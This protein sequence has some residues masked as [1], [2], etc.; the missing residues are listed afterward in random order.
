MWILF[1]IIGVLALAFVVLQMAIARDGPAVLS[2]VD[3]VFGGSQGAVLVERSQYGEVPAQ[4]LRVWR[5]EGPQEPLPIM[6]F[7][8]GGSW[9][10][11]DPDS[12][13]FVGRNL[14][15]QG[16][17]T[18]LAGYRLYPDARYP[19]MLKDTAA[20]IAWAREN[21]QRLGGDPERIWLMG[22]SAGA[23]NVVG[24]ALDQRWI[25]ERKVPPEA[26]AGVI[27][28]SGPYDF[29][30]FDSES[31]R[32]SFG[33]WPDPEATQPI[34]YTR[35]DAPKILLITG[36]Q[37]TTVKPR[38]S[39]ALAQAIEDKGGQVELEVYPEMDHSDPLVSL[40]HPWQS[41]RPVMRR[42]QKFVTREKFEK[43]IA[44][45]RESAA[46]PSL[47]VQGETR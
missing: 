44:Q 33:E 18:I 16:F 30:P 43:L 7:V 19:A 5:K 9:S 12:Y 29:Y 41:R 10:W 34:S 22:H 39:K 15:G 37:D 36:D 1:G 14:A 17:L 45:D 23:Y 38:N 47:A 25:E 40:A 32:N 3:H 42:I 26:I 31:T 20:A 35:T 6:I 13:D 11:G 46:N 24:V 28:L 2:A 8:H 4:K 27:G 21:A